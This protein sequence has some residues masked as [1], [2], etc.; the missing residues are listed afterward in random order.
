MPPFNGR[1]DKEI[2]DNVAN[3]ELKYN[4]GEF[5]S[6]SPEAKNQMKILMD[7]D[8][9]RRP[10]ALGAINNEW[11]TKVMGNLDA[12]INIKS[13]Q[14]QKNFNTKS[15]L[16]QAVYFFMVNNMATKEEKNEQIKTF[17]ALDLNGDGKLTRE[18]LMHGYNQKNI[19]FAPNDMELMLA[20]L[21]NNQSGAIDYTE[22]V[23]AAI[24][25]EKLLSKQ[26]MMQC[27]QLFDKDKSG[28]I[29]KQ[30]LKA[31]FGGN[32][33]VDENVWTEQIK[34]VDINGDGEMDF[35][36]FK[37]MLLKLA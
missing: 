27:F 11:F 9:N 2:M 28:S 31:M 32:N 24:D 19:E 12:E 18:E 20:Q 6:I 5:E 25:R 16:Q 23:A 37:E 29:S 17:K 26:R 4:L 14:N 22:F 30:E 33:K 36:E 3:Q 1:D 10:S 15:K 21:D 8:V 34:D 35:G 13:L 7:R